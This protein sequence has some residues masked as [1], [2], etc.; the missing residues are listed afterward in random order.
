MVAGQNHGGE[1]DVTWNPP[2]DP[3]VYVKGDSIPIQCL[4]NAGAMQ[5]W[6]FV[7]WGKTFILKLQQTP[8]SI[9]MGLSVDG[10]TLD[11]YEPYVIKDY[12]PH[13]DEAGKGS[14]Y[15]PEG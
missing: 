11:A 1:I 12:K 8:T 9:Y 2:R 15:N 3:I 7:A 6:S 13:A 14:M 10:D 5:E 4:S